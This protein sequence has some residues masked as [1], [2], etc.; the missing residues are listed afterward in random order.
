[1][2][3]LLTDVLF[4]N[5]FAKW[6]LVEIQSFMDTYDTDIMV[7][8][9]VN[10]YAGIQ[11]TLDYEKLDES[12]GLSK[13]YDILIFNHGYNGLNKYNPPDFDGCSFNIQDPVTRPCDYLFRK[14]Q[15]RDADTSDKNKHGITLDVYDKVYH[16][17]FMNYRYFQSSFPGFPPEI[18]YIHL[19][20]GGNFISSECAHQIHPA[21]RIIC[22]QYFIT[23]MFTGKHPSTILNAYG[24]TYF[25]KDEMITHR[26]T[27]K[28]KDS[29]IKI[30]FTSLGVGTE[31]GTDAYLEIAK[32]YTSLYG[33]S[34][35][36]IS[37]GS[38][39]PHPCIR[40]YDAMTQHDLSLFYREHVD[41]I[42]NLETG[43]GFHGFPLGI[44]GAIEGCILL[45][46]D[47]HHSNHGNGFHFDPFLILENPMV[48]EQAVEKIRHLDT[49]RSDLYDKSVA[50]QDRLFELFCYDQMMQRIFTFLETS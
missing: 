45:T 26:K 47:V 46:T 50:L 29:C 17:F 18:Q 49:H 42:L 30:C 23:E 19:Y 12:F 21:T 38:C 7:I 48:V 36:F 4:P 39:P 34:A 24:A 27:L 8:H 44:E 35:H 37:I 33:E 28:P 15:F 41:V 43:K 2:R 22:T 32:R 5:A 40:H 11:F 6:R 13:N 3:I 31:K 14:R 16:I 9:R 10:A 25:G 20:P 1:M